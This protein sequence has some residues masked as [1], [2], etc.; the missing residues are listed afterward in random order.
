MP[1]LGDVVSRETN[2]QWSLNVFRREENAEFLVTD[3]GALLIRDSVGPAEHQCRYDKRHSLRLP[4]RFGDGKIETPA[5]VFGAFES[6]VANVL[7]M[8]FH[9]CGL[10]IL[11]DMESRTANHDVRRA[12]S[13]H[14]ATKHSERSVQ[15]SPHYLDW[16]NQPLPL[17]IYT[18]VDPIPLPRDAD[19]TGI[20]ALSAIAETEASPGGEKVPNL[21]DLARILYFSA[22]ITKKRTYPGG[23][24]YFRAASCT[25]ALYEF[26]LYIV[27]GDLEDLKAGI[28][29]FGPGDFALRLLRE[30]DYRGALVRAGGGEPSLRHAPVTIVC[31]GTYW[32]NA[33]KYRAR[34]YRHFGW[35]NGTLLANMLAMTAAL[36][37]PSKVVL[38]FVDSEVNRL[39]DLDTQ[40]EVAFSMVSVGRVETEIPEASPEIPKLDLPTVPLSESEVD[41]PELR[42][43][44]EASSLHTSDEVAEWRTRAEEGAE[45]AH[46][47]PPKAAAGALTHPSLFPPLSTDT[48][49]QV[50]LRRG[51]SR[52]F[53]RQPIT[54]GQL[55][56]ILSASTQGV[57]KGFPLLND[58]YLIVNAVEG[59]RS[60]AY[61]YHRDTAGLELLK[62][63]SFRNEARFLGLQQDLPGDAAAD[64]FF[65]A[66]LDSVLTR[67]GNRGYRAVQLEAGIIGG[68]LYIASYALRLGATGLT[69]FDDDVT[70]FFSPHAKGKSAIFLVALGK[71]RKVR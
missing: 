57:W 34:T 4:P 32:R 22:G 65:L 1:E 62:E 63:G 46:P 48:I 29:H 54:H 28:Y 41:Y 24:I 35:D 49:E 52:K 30:G 21:K 39:L 42:A 3:L 23:E 68:K 58:L 27:C 12:L 64:V 38:G 5:A 37:L 9:A 17:K 51:S 55:A 60:G 70:A 71:G 25:G 33:W 43:I 59:L 19:Q 47:L 36:R 2:A 67:F 7:L 15:A 69:F 16:A 11:D 40:R 20:A 8:I 44:H 50:I 6:K 61:F 13:Y 56:T 66:D 45:G 10:I 31:A 14:E 53:E 26:E 18:T